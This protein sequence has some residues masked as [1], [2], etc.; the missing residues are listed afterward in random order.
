MKIV[1]TGGGS[2]GHITPILAVA[3]EIKQYH[4]DVQITYIGQAGDRF[5]SMVAEQPIIDEVQTVQAGKFRRYHGQGIAQLLDVHTIGLNLRDAFKALIGIWQ[6]WRILGKIKPDVVFCKGGFVGVPVG[7]AAA[8]RKIPYVTHDSDAIPG[9]AN[10]IIAKW[11]TKHAVALDAALYPYPRDKTVTVGVPV[12][13]TYQQVGAK[14]QAAYKR[15]VGLEQYELVLLVTGGGLGAQRLNDA[16]LHISGELLRMFPGLCI[17]HT[18]GQKHEVDVSEAYSKNLEAELRKRVIVRDFL[19]NLYA[20]SGAADVVIARGGATNL[21]E[22]ALQ[23]KPCIIVP[24][25]LLTGGHQLKN[26]T[27]YV[28]NNAI[29]VVEELDLQKPETLLAQTATL[30]QDPTRRKVLSQNLA[31]FARPDATKALAT[32][33]WKAGGKTHA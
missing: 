20:Y 25:P 32:I 30:L 12:A 22:L 7:L 18:A 23:A 14:H 24:N 19:P 3:H 11:A 27:A 16:L 33:L 4:N 31:Q 9:L 5:G 21:A 17:V 10:R 15:L 26:A 2:G 8:L 1:M 13:D 28:K 6:A 29:I